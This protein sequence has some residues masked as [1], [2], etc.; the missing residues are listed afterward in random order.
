MKLTIIGGGGI[1]TPLAVPPILRRAERMGLEE[2]CLMDIDADKL[3]IFGALA[4]P[5]GGDLRITTTTDAEEALDGAEYVITT[6]RVGGDRG[7]VLDERIALRHGVLGQETTGAG[8]FAMALRSIPTLLDYARRDAWILNFTNPAGLV[9]Q[10]LYDRGFERVVGI[11]DSANGAQHAVA[12]WL[13]LDAQ[14][15]RAEVFGLNHLSWT[16]S[17]KRGDEDLLAGLL[18]DPDF[19]HETLLR[20]FDPALIEHLGMWPNEYLYY[21]YYS[22]Q[23]FAE[24]MEKEHT[25]GESIQAWNQELLSQLDSDD[26]EAARRHYNTYMARRTGT[27]MHY[28]ESTE[29]GQHGGEEDEGYM[30]VALDTILSLSTGEPLY[31]ALNVPNNG[32]IE[33][34]APDDVVEV[35]CRVDGDGVHPLPIG[36]IPEHQELLMRTVKLYERRTV[37][38][39]LTRSRAKAIQALMVHPLIFSYALAETL[40]DEYLEAHAAYA[41]EWV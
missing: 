14:Q 29:G 5:A 34:M 17:V 4:A 1:R 35:S 38:A 37:E 6:I 24:I 31:T 19:R 21:W 18:Q 41:G 11:C 16:R 26:L 25:R 36:A 20:L 2:L 32:A 10:A 3:R 27:Y 22:K 28:G 8:G 33:C 39:I 12:G 23:A 15:L 13:G 7:R 30:G 9:T 40:V